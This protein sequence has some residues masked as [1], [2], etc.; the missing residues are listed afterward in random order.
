MT[1]LPVPTGRAG[2]EIN[3]L[4]KIVHQFGFIYNI[5]G[6]GIALDLTNYLKV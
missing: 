4:R 3:I 2:Q 5:I 6:G 1:D